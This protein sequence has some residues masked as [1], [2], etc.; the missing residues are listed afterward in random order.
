MAFYKIWNRAGSG[1]GIFSIA[2]F[3]CGSGSVP[4]GSSRIMCFEIILANS[5][6]HR[7]FLKYDYKYI[8]MFYLRLKYIM[9]TT[10]NQTDAIGQFQGPSDHSIAIDIRNYKISQIIRNQIV[11]RSSL[12]FFSWELTYSRSHGRQNEADNTN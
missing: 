12:V 10:R 5:I 7:R 3:G 2:R 1:S 11:T 9:S 6:Y 4:S 8:T